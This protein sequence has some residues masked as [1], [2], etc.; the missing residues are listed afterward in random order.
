MSLTPSITPGRSVGRVEPPVILPRQP[1][2]SEQ[3]VDEAAED[4]GLVK[5]RSSQ[6]KS[7]RA[8]GQSPKSFGAVSV[9][10]GMLMFSTGHMM[11]LADEAKAAAED[12]DDA[13]IKT[14]LMNIRRDAAHEIV[15]AAKIILDSEA[16]KPVAAPL[17]DEDLEEPGQYIANSR[18]L[19]QVAVAGDVHIH[20]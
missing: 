5:F 3:E 13:E 17:K 15:V 12:T 2:I 10:R 19:T 1:K 18:A 9:A 4:L 6:I 20:G 14:K 16:A 11:E 8:L 7:L